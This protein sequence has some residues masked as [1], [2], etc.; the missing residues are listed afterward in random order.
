MSE[1]NVYHTGPTAP[2]SL[3]AAA[4]GSIDLSGKRHVKIKADLITNPSARLYYRI[5]YSDA[6]AATDLTNAEDYLIDGEVEE[7][8]LD[9]RLTPYLY[10]WLA[11]SAGSEVTGGAS[12]YLRKFIEE[13]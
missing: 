1:Q 11:D 13:H 4:S 9:P 5:G 10:W 7:L 3:N 8:W 2:T 6:L 12:D